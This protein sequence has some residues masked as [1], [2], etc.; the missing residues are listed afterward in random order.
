MRALIVSSI[1]DRFNCHSS[2]QQAKVDG[3]GLTISMN[4][5]QSNRHL[6]YAATCAHA[7]GNVR[8]L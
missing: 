1:A 4:F 8:R 2:D 5:A 7:F 6:N 3:C